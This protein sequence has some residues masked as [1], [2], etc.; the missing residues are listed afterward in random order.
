MLAK[1]A[2]QRHFFKQFPLINQKKSFFENSLIDSSKAREPLHQK[3]ALPRESRAENDKAS[4]Q[5]SSMADAFPRRQM[6]QAQSRNLQR[7]RD[8]LHHF[9]FQPR[10]GSQAQRA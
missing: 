6:G 9:H 8:L 2:I 4:P 10:R 1:K 3:G 7:D 5:P